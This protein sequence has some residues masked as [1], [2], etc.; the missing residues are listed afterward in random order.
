MMSDDTYMPLLTLFVYLGLWRKIRSTELLLLIYLIINVIFGT[1]TNVM[2]FYKINNLAYY[3]FYTLFEQWFISFYLIRK[4]LNSRIPKAF[5]LINIGFTIF[6]VIN[7]LGWEPLNVF[8][9]NTAVISN[10]ILLL[11]C[12]YYMLDLSKKE[13]ILYFQKLPSFWI[14][15]GFFIYSALSVLIF[16]VYKYY[17]LQN[18]TE[19]GNRIYTLIHVTT[20]VK[21]ILIFVGLLCYRQRISIHSSSLLSGRS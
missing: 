2:G 17:V 11:L 14:V 6:W 4:T 1:I 3:H 8:N 9:S 21:Y 20:E 7:I 16:A 15:S 19:E 5:F 13:E 10:L 12:M 18:L